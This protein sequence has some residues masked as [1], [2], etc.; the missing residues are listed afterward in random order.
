METFK[1]IAK[2]AAIMFVVGALLAMIAPIITT[3]LQF[4]S[5]VEAAIQTLGFN[6]KPL[7]LGSFFAAFGAIQASVTPAFNW[8]SGDTKKAVNEVALTKTHGCQHGHGIASHNT[9]IQPD[10]AVEAN[11]KTTDEPVK[12]HAQAIEAQR[13]NGSNLRLVK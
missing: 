9:Q 5:T 11:I 12:L 2:T 7:W 10:I 8:L 13:A 1:N 3:A 6:A 4:E